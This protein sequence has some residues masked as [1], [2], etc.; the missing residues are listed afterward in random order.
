MGIFENDS[1]LVL[2]PGRFLNCSVMLL[3]DLKEGQRF[4]FAD[5]TSDI[6]LVKGAGQVPARGTFVFVRN[7]EAACPVLRKVETGMVFTAVANTYYR[8]VTILF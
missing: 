7:G 3:K 2:E 1:G 4:E 8:W 5:K 6:Q